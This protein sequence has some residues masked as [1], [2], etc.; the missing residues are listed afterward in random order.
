[1]VWKAWNRPHPRN[2][3]ILIQIIVTLWKGREISY[4][5]K[6]N[7][8]YFNEEKVGIIQYQCH[9]KTQIQLFILLLIV[10]RKENMSFHDKPTELPVSFPLPLGDGL[11]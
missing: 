10:Q 5:V 11:Y 1:M 7:P 2:F 8:L 9:L 3:F 6:C 4:I